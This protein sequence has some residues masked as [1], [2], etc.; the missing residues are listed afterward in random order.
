MKPT[1]LLIATVVISVGITFAQKADVPK[2]PSA[3][4]LASEKV[5]ELLL[6]MDTNKDGKISKA[7]WMKFMGAQFDRFDRQKRGELDPKEIVQS[8]LSAA[9]PSFATSGK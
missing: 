5:R 7:E 6:L 2:K 4:A 3:T 8:K 1:Y 9:P